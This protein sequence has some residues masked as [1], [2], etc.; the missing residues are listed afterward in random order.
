[1]RNFILLALALQQ[2]CSCS[3]AS[4]ESTSD[5]VSKSEDTATLS[6]SLTDLTDPLVRWSNQRLLRAVATPEAMSY[7]LAPLAWSI[8]DRWV[9]NNQ[10]AGKVRVNAPPRD[11]GLNIY[12]IKREF[13]TAN[14]FTNLEAVCPCEYLVGTKS[15]VCVDDALKRATTSLDQHTVKR[16]GDDKDV[17]ESIQ[18]IRRQHRTFMS[19]WIIAH[20]LG[21]LVL[22]HTFAD[23]KKSWGFANQ[24]VGIDAERE[25]DLYYL[26][27]LQH[28]NFSQFSSIMGLSQLMTEQYAE[29]LVRQN[30]RERLENGEIVVFAANT[31]VKLEVSPV[32]HPPMLL[33]AV[34]L[35]KTLLSRYPGMVDSSGYVDRIASQ[36]RPVLVP[37]TEPPAFCRRATTAPG[38]TDEPL[39]T[40]ALYADFYLYDGDQGWARST[41]GRIQ[42]QIE[43]AQR[44][45]TWKRRWHATVA[46]A[47]ARLDWKFRKEVPDWTSL[48]AMSANLDADSKQL[49]AIQSEMTKSFVGKR[50]A[51]KDGIEAAK[52]IEPII[53][54]LA[55]KKSISVVD[56]DDIYD[57]ISTY[58]V[59]S[60]SPNGKIDEDYLGYVEQLVERITSLR[61]IS[62]IRRRIFVDTIRDFALNLA[63]KDGG[64][65]FAVVRLMSLLVGVANS[66]GWPAE[67]IDYRASEIGFL[68]EYFP[69]QR[70]VIA[71]REIAFGQML[72]RWGQAAHALVVTQDALKQVKAIDASQRS[73]DDRRR[74]REWKL[75]IEND[76][77]WLMIQNGKYDEAVSILQTVLQSR[78]NTQD[79]TLSCN[80]KSETLHVYQNLADAYLALGIWSKA[81]T[82]A[83]QAGACVASEPNSKEWYDA[84]KTTG[85]ALAGAGEKEEAE[86]VLRDFVVKLAADLDDNQIARVAL[87]ATANGKQVSVNDVINVKQEI[88]K[89]RRKSPNAD[90]PTDDKN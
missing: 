63:A 8:A 20:E 51:A 72:P 37:H 89:A 59:I 19:E 11:D 18:L 87:A 21:H 77:G 32:E 40:L 13:L 85:L 34:N 1:M 65:R 6:F 81:V 88:Q 9:R 80:N 86:K 25:A 42:R 46:H 84:A 24:Q 71:N 36:I 50:G 74:L 26:S 52:R 14:R 56:D 41:I 22:D 61:N 58:L 82:F 23:L 17:N 66:F 4:A 35:Y 16:D 15:I 76:I 70:S 68:K 38:P 53:K 7:E 28:Q 60:F 48:D 44:S 27:A 33:R 78:Q 5:S 47:T 90:G 67:E 57:I 39:D 69:E 10:W 45:D 3:L 54:E 73:E 12:I 30:G 62:P 43:S 29:Q 49:I 64:H 2:F 75:K 31:P 79:R 83:K 55:S